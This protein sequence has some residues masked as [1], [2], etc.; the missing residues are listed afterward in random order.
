M[1]NINT[2][3][4]RYLCKVVEAIN[5][6]EKI[7]DVVGLIRNQISQYRSII[8]DVGYIEYLESICE[9][10]VGR[11]CIFGQGTK[12]TRRL[13]ILGRGAAMVNPDRAGNI[14]DNL[15]VLKEEY[16]AER[17]SNN[18]GTQQTKTVAVKTVPPTHTTIEDI[19]PSSNKDQAKEIIRQIMQGRRGKGAC[20]AIR[21]LIKAK[22]ISC[23]QFDRRAIYGAISNFIGANIGSDAS[24][25]KYWADDT[26]EG[27]IAKIC[28]QIEQTIRQ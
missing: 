26:V 20:V 9:S 15:R 25:N 2:I 16:R 13:S 14:Y 6:G 7:D 17:L 1:E 8:G 23:E 4:E 10:D 12:L 22:I 11:P 27:E 5:D 28:K 24:I 21:A 3:R 18:Q 19:I